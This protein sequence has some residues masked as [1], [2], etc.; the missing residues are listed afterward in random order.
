MSPAGPVAVVCIR[1]SGSAITEIR[2]CFYFVGEIKLNKSQ[3][4]LFAERHQYQQWKPARWGSA[5][6]YARKAAA[7]TKRSQIMCICAC[8]L[9]LSSA[10]PR[11]ELSDSSSLPQLFFSLPDWH[12]ILDTR[13]SLLH[14]VR[15]FVSVDEWHACFHMRI[16]HTISQ[17]TCL[18]QY[19]T[20]PPVCPFNAQSLMHV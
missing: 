4:W 13:V 17:A 14:A 2:V 19:A 20:F 11:R 1:C 10:T 15:R 3:S 5:V 7:I 18:N 6:N 16:Y 8:V 9:V 12:R